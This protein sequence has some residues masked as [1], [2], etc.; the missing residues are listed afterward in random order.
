MLSNEQPELTL[1]CSCREIIQRLIN[2]TNL[3]LI[4][5][6]E[7]T[8]IVDACFL[9]SSLNIIYF[10]L[11]EIV[12]ENVLAS[13]RTVRHRRRKSSALLLTEK[14]KRLA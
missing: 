14:S 2:S 9:I 12:D 3:F 6:C 13:L 10:S 11:K 5:F 8:V 4:I 1:N 7:F